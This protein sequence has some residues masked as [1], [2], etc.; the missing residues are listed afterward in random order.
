MLLLKKGRRPSYIPFKDWFFIRVK[1]TSA[2]W[3]WIGYSKNGRYGH[4]SVKGKSKPAHVH[5]WEARRGLVPEGFEVCHRCDN[6]RCVR[7]GH[8]FLA[9]HRDNILDASK[10]KR[11]WRRETGNKGYNNTFRKG[12]LRLAAP[13]A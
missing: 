2:C 10:K 8:L 6:P 13:R 12:S 4:C 3:I 11:L 5:H 7:L 9:T 1:K